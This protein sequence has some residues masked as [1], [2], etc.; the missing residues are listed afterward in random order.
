MENITFKFSFSL[1]FGSFRFWMCFVAFDFYSSKK[2]RKS[3][4]IKQTKNNCLLFA[5]SNISWEKY[6]HKFVDKK[7]PIK[8]VKLCFV[9]QIR[10]FLWKVAN[11]LLF[12]T[13]LLPL[14]HYPKWCVVCLWL[15]VLLLLMMM[16]TTFLLFVE[17]IV[18]IHC[19]NSSSKYS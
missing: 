8:Y 2:V 7:S 14:M 3:T 5:M 11:I 12:G 6:S 4:W 18:S 17:L 15:K 9:N 10:K 13:L 19:L 1:S 16:M